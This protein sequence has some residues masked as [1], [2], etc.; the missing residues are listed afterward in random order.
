MQK[1][2]AIYA[3]RLR[4]TITNEQLTPLMEGMPEKYRDF[5]RIAAEKKTPLS[6]NG[7]SNVEEAK[8][9][10]AFMKA[11]DAAELPKMI[12]HDLTRATVR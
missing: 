2:S 9:I 3:E 10:R 12:F 8:V 6:A 11:R 1:R 7:L 4:L 5:V